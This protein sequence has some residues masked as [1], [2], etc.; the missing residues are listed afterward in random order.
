MDAQWAPFC[1]PCLSQYCAFRP[2][3]CDPSILLAIQ[4]LP[5]CVCLLSGQGRSG[6]FQ[7]GTFVITVAISINDW[8]CVFLVSK[9]RGAQW[10]SL[11]LCLCMFSL[12]G[13]PQAIFQRDFTNLHFY[14]QQFLL[15]LYLS[16]PVLSILAIHVGGAGAGLY[17]Y[18]DFS[19]NCWQVCFLSEACISFPSLAVDILLFQFLLKVIH[20]TGNLLTSFLCLPHLCIVLSPSRLLSATL[21]HT[22]QPRL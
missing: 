20:P 12:C 8:I 14:P 3:C 22:S 1:I 11:R 18:F 10:L 9:H 16:L 17:L 7:L 4:D 21:A 6:S 2:C 5:H 13:Y 15:F 19:T